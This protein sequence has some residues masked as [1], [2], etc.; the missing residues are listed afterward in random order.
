MLD[1]NYNVLQDTG[2]KY[3][4]SMEVTFYGLN[5][6]VG[7]IYYAVLMVEDDLSNSL[8]FAVQITVQ[9]SENV[10]VLEIPFTA[11]YDC[12]TRSVKVVYENY[13]LVKPVYIETDEQEQEIAYV[14]NKDNVGKSWDNSLYYG[15]NL[16]NNM[17]ISN[18]NK[19][20]SVPLFNIY[21]GESGLSETSKNGVLYNNFFKKDQ[22]SIEAEEQELK[23]N[24]IINDDNTT[25]NKFLFTTAI[26][27]YSTFRGTLANIELTDEDTDEKINIAFTVDMINSQGIL[28]N[29]VKYH[30]KKD[31]IEASY[32]LYSYR[33]D[34][35]KCWELY[36]L[37]SFISPTLGDHMPSTSAVYYYLQN[38]KIDSE[39]NYF[40]TTRSPFNR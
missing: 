17:Y 28:E 39:I 40:F 32:N 38:K 1:K 3:D 7:N 4:K 15:I 9:E 11:K 16:D 2:K 21:N 19:N 20:T 27:P 6:E 12:A 31:D 29:S 30:I 22:D 8:S 5:N 24:S 37:S 36:L 26:K 23:I 13:G 33:D 34:N 35:D 25:T 10:E 18:A 14:Y